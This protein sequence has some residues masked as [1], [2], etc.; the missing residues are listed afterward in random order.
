MNKQQKRAKT[1]I[2]YMGFKD[3]DL[4]LPDHDVWCLKLLNPKL[5]RKILESHYNLNSKKIQK[6]LIKLTDYDGMVEYLCDDGQYIE[7]Y[8]YKDIQ[9]FEK[10]CDRSYVILNEKLELEHVLTKHGYNGYSQRLGFVD[11]FYW[12]KIISTLEFNINGAT[13]KIENSS[14]EKYILFFE[15]KVKKQTIGSITREVEYYRDVIN[16]I[17]H[18]KIKP[19]VVSP[20]KIPIN[21]F[22]S[23]S[24]EEILHLEKEVK[25]NE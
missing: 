21:Q 25:M 3:P 10:E 7:E 4:F 19:I 14:S 23:M 18:T 15:V 12:V 1:L 13:H 24:F 8:G 2:E 16:E 11:V 9:R 20:E 17:Y 6:N 5:V 22:D